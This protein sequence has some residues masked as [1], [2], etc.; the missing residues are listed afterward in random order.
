MLC[1]TG[2]PSIEVTLAY[3]NKHITAGVK[4]TAHSV[5]VQRSGSTSVSWMSLSVKR[6]RPD[7]YKYVNIKGSYGVEY[8]PKRRVDQEKTNQHDEQK[9]DHSE[10]M[11][12]VEEGK[13]KRKWTGEENRL[14]DGWWCV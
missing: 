1:H 13:R 14:M 5:R 7:K 10:T 9:D 6:N 12:K 2:V 4:C 8:V 11:A 3:H